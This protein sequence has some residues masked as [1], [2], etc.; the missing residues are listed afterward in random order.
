[1]LLYA[2]EEKRQCQAFSKWLRYSIDQQRAVS[3]SAEEETFDDPGIDYNL[4]LDYI[5]GALQASRVRPFL[6]KEASQG[7]LTLDLD[8]KALYEEVRKATL[9]LK[10]GLGD[11]ARSDRLS[12]WTIFSLI[13]KRSDQLF[14]KITGWLTKEMRMDCGLI[15]EDEKMSGVRDV[16]SMRDVSHNAHT[17]GIHVYRFSPITV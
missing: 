5:K 10:D 4:T 9:L 16:Q 7:D 15:L 2:A 14:D 1:M 3:N 11:Q 12:F 13:R 8:P 6:N 17:G